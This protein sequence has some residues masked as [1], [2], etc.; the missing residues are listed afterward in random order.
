MRFVVFLAI[1]CCLVTKSNACSFVSNYS[2]GG[3]RTTI[4]QKQSSSSNQVNKKGQ[5][6]IVLDDCSP[7]T[8][9]ETVM[10]DDEV[11]DEDVAIL[12]PVRCK[13]AAARH[14]TLYSFI[15]DLNDAAFIDTHR[16]SYYT[17]GCSLGQ[18]SP[19]YI[20]QGVLRI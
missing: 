2:Y 10:S 6:S 14:H 12:A 8:D 15:N 16:N 9:S 1:L 13:Y 4:P 11:E 5:E 20:L 7:N 19:K 3:I 18:L 17:A